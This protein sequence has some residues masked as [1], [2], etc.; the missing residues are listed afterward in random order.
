[1]LSGIARSREGRKVGLEGRNV[2]LEVCRN[3]G[4]EEG[5]SRKGRSRKGRSRRRQVSKVGLKAGLEGRSQR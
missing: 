1:M 4:L 3:I 2:G 5:R